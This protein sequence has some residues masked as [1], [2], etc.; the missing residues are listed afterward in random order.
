MFLDVTAIDTVVLKFLV[1]ESTMEGS[2]AFCSAFGFGLV[3]F[4][5]FH[6]RMC[7]FASSLYFLCCI[8]FKLTASR[9]VLFICKYF[10]KSLES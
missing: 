8:V 9:L 2:E 5:C 1:T 6:Y 7:A 3:C 4:M 10:Y